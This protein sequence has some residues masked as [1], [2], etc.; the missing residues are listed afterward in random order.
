MQHNLTD[1]ISERLYFS[2]FFKLREQWNY[3]NVKAA[4]FMRGFVIKHIVT[5]LPKLFPLMSIM[6]D[7]RV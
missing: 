4:A 7:L 3:K 1:W 2:L 5:V 6:T